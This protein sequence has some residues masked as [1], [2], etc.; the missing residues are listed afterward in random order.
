MSKN[1]RLEILRFINSYRKHIY[2]FE[3][4]FDEEPINVPQLLQKCLYVYHDGIQ[5][6]TSHQPGG[7]PTLFTKWYILNN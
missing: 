6:G 3:S 5:N 1:F 2:M 4:S 7:K